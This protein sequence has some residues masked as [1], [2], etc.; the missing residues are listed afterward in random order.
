MRTV[1]CA[2]LVAVAWISTASAQQP[3]WDMDHGN[4]AAAVNAANAAAAAAQAKAAAIA[5]GRPLTPSQA[6]DFN[7]NGKTVIRDAPP[8]TPEEQKADAEARSAWQAR[9]RPAVVADSEGIRRTK[10]AESDCDLSRFNTAG[11]Q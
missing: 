11:A 8:P 7:I 5:A 1:S 9:C 10:Y 2:L 6:T 4:A 3:S